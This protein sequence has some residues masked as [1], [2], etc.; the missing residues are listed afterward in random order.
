MK[1]ITKSVLKMKGL[2]T[3]VVFFA[4]VLFV[5]PVSVFAGGKGEKAEEP[6]AAAEMVKSEYGGRMTIGFTDPLETLALDVGTFYTN[7]GSLYYILVY[8]NLQRFSKPPNYYAFTPEFAESYELAEDR[9]S[10]ILHLKKGAKWHDGVPVTAADV[11]FTMENLW[12]ITAWA[13]PELDIESTEIIDDYTL[14]VNSNLKV[15]GANPPGFWAWDPIVPKHILEDH[16]NEIETWENLEAIGSGPY[17]L[18]EFQPGE[19]MWLVANDDYY[20]GRP[21]LDEVVFKYYGNIDT[22]VM[23]L[24]KGDIDTISDENIP[25]QLIDKLNSDPNITVEVVDGLT[26]EWI[27]FNLH[28]E[29]PLQDINVRLAIQHA[30]DRDRLID[31]VYMGHA[32]KYNSWIYEED[33]LYN[34]NLPEFEYDV[35]KSKKILAD[36]G[37]ADS[38]GDGLLNDPKTGDNLSFEL[39]V[40]SEAIYEVKMGTLIGEMLPEIG[41]GIDLVTTDTDTFWEYYYYPTEDAYEMA[42][43]GED[44]A[45]APYSDWIWAMASS[46]EDAEGEEWNSSYWANA[47]FDELMYSLAEAGSVEERK[48]ISF[49][50]QEIMAAEIPYGFLVRPKFIS[51][52]R[53][54][55]IKGW[56]IQIG[57]A[58]SWMND[59]SITDGQLK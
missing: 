9:Y 50:M 53:T 34:P 12:S 59:W 31:M 45:P 17:K 15:S 11:K 7:W 46:W 26:L 3:L 14:K 44:P 40:A 5:L 56:Y 39:L 21:K 24:Q 16:V 42:I 10:Y 52:Y 28:K 57:G 2:N 33:K 1:E 29:G 41:I 32:S 30:I 43:A 20:G 51:A 36:A 8:D 22:M 25:P 18:K 55:K 13:D 23:A 37:Y 35:A 54:D 48:E 4:I 58:V 27:S 47:E 49:K 6:E 38:D 19:F